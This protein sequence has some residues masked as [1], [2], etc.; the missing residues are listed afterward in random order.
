MST[1][2]RR[3]TSEELQELRAGWDA[4]DGYDAIALRLMKRFRRRYTRN[5]VAGQCKKHGLTRGRV[6]RRPAHIGWDK[7]LAE[8]AMGLQPRGEFQESEAERARRAEL[9]RTRAERMA[10]RDKL[11]KWALE[12][13]EAG[14]SYGA[15]A[16]KTGLKAK[17]I[18]WHCI[19]NGVFPP[20]IK[21]RPLPENP[22]P[23]NRCG[24]PVSRAEEDEM[25]RLALAGLTPTEIARRVGRGRALVVY[26]LAV[27]AARDEPELSG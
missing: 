5:M 8:E 4:G 23:R 14:K 19:I 18:R 26:R 24:T 12:L 2:R 10:K 15:I 22:R 7:I 16:L 27:K 1:P 13:R 17:L 21:P 11:I 20:G 25:E 3:W 9:D 6:S